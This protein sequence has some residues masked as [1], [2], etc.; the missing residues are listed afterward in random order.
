MRKVS[1]SSFRLLVVLQT[2]FVTNGFK[3]LNHLFVHNFH[4]YVQHNQRGLEATGVCVKLS[5]AAGQFAAG[6]ELRP[7]G[8]WTKLELLSNPFIIY[9]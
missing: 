9:I 5:R 2:A 7:R 1:S 6:S 4:K 8:P 3:V